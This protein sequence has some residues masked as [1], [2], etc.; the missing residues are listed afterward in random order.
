MPALRAAN[1]LGTA[2]YTLG[3]AG[4]PQRPPTRGGGG[5][6]ALVWRRPGSRRRRIGHG[7]SRWRMA[8]GR[9]PGKALMINDVYNANPTSMRAALQA[10]AAAYS[11]RAGSP[12][13]GKI[14]A[15]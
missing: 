11:D 7:G 8:V 15:S 1:T 9:L 14:Q 4:T 5:G 6:G 12:L 2:A 13:L 3:V 10:L